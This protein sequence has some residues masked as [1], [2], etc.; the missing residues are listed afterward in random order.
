MQLTCNC[1]KCGQPVTVS[2]PEVDES[3]AEY[4]SRLVLCSDC[5]PRAAIER[6]VNFVCGRPT[7]LTLLERP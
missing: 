6:A 4:L 7:A 5:A 3:D 1:C 2:L